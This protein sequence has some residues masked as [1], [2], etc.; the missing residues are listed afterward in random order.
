MTAEKLR[1]SRRDFLKVIVLGVMTP[2]VSGFEVAEAAS[3][4]VTD[5][6]DAPHQTYLPQAE[7]AASP[8]ELFKQ[9]LF[10]LLKQAFP[11]L[12][13]V[14]IVGDGTDITGFMKSSL[15]W[16][17]Q[18]QPLVKKG[19]DF[20]QVSG[21]P[22]HMYQDSARKISFLFGESAGKTIVHNDEYGVTEIEM[23][24]KSNDPGSLTGE[25]LHLYQAD[26]R[27]SNGISAVN[28]EAASTAI[29]LEFL[30]M[31]RDHIK[32][33]VDTGSTDQLL[34]MPI[35]NLYTGERIENPTADQ[36]LDFMR[37]EIDLFT[38]KINKAIDSA[39]K[40]EFKGQD[41]L[42]Q[43]TSYHRATTFLQD[44]LNADTFPEQD[45]FDGIEK[46]ADVFAA[47]MLDLNNRLS[48]E[49]L[50]ML[51]SFIN[52]GQD[53]ASFVYGTPQNV[54]DTYY[55]L[56]SAN[57]VASAE[58]WQLN[59]DQFTQITIENM[60][61][62]AVFALKSDERDSNQFLTLEGYATYTDV[63]KDGTVFDTLPRE[64]LP[65]AQLFFPYVDENG[66]RQW[67]QKELLVTPKY[68]RDTVMFGIEIPTSIPIRP[69]LLPKYEELSGKDMVLRVTQP[70]IFGVGIGTIQD[71]EVKGVFPEGASNAA[72]S[73]APT[74][75]ESEALAPGVAP[76]V[77]R[78]VTR[79]QVSYAQLSEAGK[80]KID[81]AKAKLEQKK[82][83]STTTRGVRYTTL[84]QAA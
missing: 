70:T 40:K 17:E 36:F 74:P 27:I 57:L 46:H 58:Q 33:A 13:E 80:A 60:A 78:Q 26:T 12:E 81:Q 59:K 38:L 73:A 25:L 52:H 67:F 8:E 9:P 30:R 48:F 50:V 2:G 5:A 47:K 53:P 55:S 34:L 77:E 4:P 75:S 28:E 41:T 21:I 23:H 65:T 14:E 22:H 76:S 43:S 72:Q 32:Q 51:C 79:T 71:F 49:E 1:F 3:P 45:Y 18:L 83:G 69:G 56:R 11:L 19:R 68:D 6:P 20:V 24:V 54:I 61:V 16:I 44:R 42:G 62:N 31:W 82:S 37:D 35:F 39:Y 7:V 66:L 15:Y 64:D 63:G 10:D 29:D 84:K